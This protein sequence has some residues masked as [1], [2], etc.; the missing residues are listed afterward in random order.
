MTRVFSTDSVWDVEEQQWYEAFFVNKEEVT[1]EEYFRELESEQCLEN[2]EEIEEEFCMCCS[3]EK[4]D[5]MDFKCTCGDLEIEN[6]NVIDDEVFECDCQDCVEQRRLD[7]LEY[8]EELCFCPECR[9]ESEQKLITECIDLVFDPESC[10][11]CMINKI[12]DTLYTFK[13]LGYRES[14]NEMKMF[15]ED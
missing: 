9:V 3:C 2:D 8:E 7:S 5:C 10:M 14:Q 4:E 11:E 13:G 15:L 12:I 6:E 1:Q